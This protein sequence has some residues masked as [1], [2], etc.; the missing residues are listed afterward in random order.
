MTGYY[1]LG[2]AFLPVAFVIWL[3]LRLFRVDTKK[4]ELGPGTISALLALAVIQLG[5][6]AFVVIGILDL[7]GIVDGHRLA[8]DWHITNANCAR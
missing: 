5:F 7:L 2:I 3:L 8:C 6:G 1:I 4:N